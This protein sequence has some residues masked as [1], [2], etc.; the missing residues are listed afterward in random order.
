M[1][2]HGAENREIPAK[3][4]GVSR[5]FGDKTGRNK[6]VGHDE[7]FQPLTKAQLIDKAENIGDDEPE[8]DNREMLGRNIIFE[9]EH[10]AAIP[11]QT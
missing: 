5:L 8:I 7:V 9:R 10:T 3:G 2:K 6:T 11:L 1:K 4:H